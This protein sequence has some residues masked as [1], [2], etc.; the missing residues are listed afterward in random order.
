M[1][2]NFVSRGAR[3]FANK[4]GSTRAMYGFPIDRRDIAYHSI[5]LLIAAGGS[6]FTAYFRWAYMLTNITAEPS[7]NH[8]M[9]ITNNIYASRRHQTFFFPR[10][11]TTRKLTSLVI[12]PFK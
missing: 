3:V 4:I 6:A 12:P 2:V 1:G 11:E 5:Y 8:H 10:V 9:E 7:R